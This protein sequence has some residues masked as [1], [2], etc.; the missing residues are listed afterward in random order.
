MTKTESFPSTHLNLWEAIC[1]LA[2]GIASEN[3]GSDWREA[4]LAGAGVMSEDSRKDDEKDR[5]TRDKIQNE[6]TNRFFWAVE[7]LERA[8]EAEEIQVLGHR[9][10]HAELPL[11]PSK[12][13]INGSL[14]P[15]GKTGGCLNPAE[16]TVDY[17]RRVWM[18]LQFKR[19]EIEG[20][21]AIHHYVDPVA[22]PPVTTAQRNE[23]WAD[24]AKI[25]HDQGM[26]WKAA[27]TAIG[28]SDKADGDYVAWVVRKILNAPKR[29]S[30]KTI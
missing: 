16:G 6:E 25:M 11:I 2:Y 21:R 15:I 26:T 27:G 24:R 14:D 3:G 28:T 13:F 29:E 12:D 8:A 7:T 23:D 30:G 1:L 5:H 17:D 19:A 22:S 20:L 9:E 18:G 4:E 10:H